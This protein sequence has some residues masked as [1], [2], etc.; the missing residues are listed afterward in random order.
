MIV[1]RENPCR[2]Q[3]ELH[4]IARSGFLPHQD[5]CLLRKQDILQEQTLPRHYVDH[6]VQSKPSGHKE[7]EPLS[8]LR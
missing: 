8:F 7:L 6:F 2:H 1:N 3:I 5:G 4:G